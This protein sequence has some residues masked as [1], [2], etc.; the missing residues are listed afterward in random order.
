M[1]SQF[2]PLNAPES[3]VSRQ[4]ECPGESLDPVVV[5]EAFQMMRVVE[6]RKSMVVEPLDIL[7]I[8][9]LIFVSNFTEFRTGNSMKNAPKIF[10][11]R[12]F[13]ILG[14]YNQFE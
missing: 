5:A 12:F 7:E 4:M 10:F 11:C 2:L 8:F 1:E 9:S 14:S 13:S 3:P 6:Q